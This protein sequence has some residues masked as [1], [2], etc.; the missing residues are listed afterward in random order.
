[1]ATY[2]VLLGPPGAGKG[3]Q[4]KK[5]AGRLKLPHVSSGDLFREHLRGETELGVKAKSYI[6]RGDLVPDDVTI[7][8]VRERLERPDCEGGAILDGFPRTPTQAEG[9]QEILGSF[10]SSLEAVLYIEVSEPELLKRLTGRRV[11]KAHGHIYHVGFNPPQVDGVCDIDGSELI[12][13]D[14]DK[15]ETVRNRIQVYWEQTAPLVDFYR[16]K[17]LLIEVDGEQPVEA[18][19]DEMLAAIKEEA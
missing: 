2:L 3:T 13:R 1:M 18:V 14:D 5:L 12:Q 8:M 11:C 15:E 17:G 9:L 6:D 16:D 7:A 19:T 4:A 10:G